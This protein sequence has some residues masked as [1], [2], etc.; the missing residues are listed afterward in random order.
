[1]HHAGTLFDLF[2]QLHVEQHR[3]YKPTNENFNAGRGNFEGMHV[4]NY[5]FQ[6]QSNQCKLQSKDPET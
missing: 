3:G 1:V 5:S 2:D 6:N 4:E